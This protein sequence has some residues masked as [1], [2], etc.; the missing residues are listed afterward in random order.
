MKKF[1]F[2]KFIRATVFV[3]A[4]FVFIF[5]G[6]KVYEYISDAKKSRES[7]TK[8]IDTA[9][10]P[11]E[12]VLDVPQN[13]ENTSHTIEEYPFYPDF[14]E[15]QKINK[16]I[17]AWVWCE[18][19]PLH[20]PV[21]QSYD[22]EYYLHRLTDHSWNFS[23]TPF[24]DYRNKSD[25]SDFN[26]IIYAHNMLNGTM[27]ASLYEWEDETFRRE[28]PIIT[29]FTPDGVV[30]VKV[31]AAFETDMKSF[32]YTIPSGEDLREYFVNRLTEKMFPELDAQIGA[33]NKF[34]TLS[35]CTKTSKTRFVVVGQTDF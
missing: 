5:S 7:I 15:L 20:Y 31:L 19:T 35:T 27:F 13:Q 10:V 4:L 26:T 17:I 11:Q 22:N 33:E 28:H 18:E 21:V 1:N 23:G 32:V 29:L 24:A 25:F 8:L 12:S 3:V 14:E 9:F 30:R 34:V 2:T 16:D 6:I